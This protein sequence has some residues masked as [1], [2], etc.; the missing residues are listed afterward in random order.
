MPNTKIPHRSRERGA[1]ASGRFTLRRKLIWLLVPLLFV[2][3]APVIILS[4]WP[5]SSG[6]EP[7]ISYPEELR[8]Q[9]VQPADRFMQSVVTDDG[10]LGWHQLCPT[11][12]AQLPMDELVQQ[13][14][15]QRDVVVKQ[16]VR[17]TFKRVSVRSRQASGT[18]HEYVVT[19][20]WPNGSTQTRTFDVMTQP[21]GCVE[22][23]Q[24]H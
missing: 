21:S 13:A 9:P 15:A 14:N 16:G 17:L 4:Q 2:L 24:N 20:R 8:S 18:V 10:A 12:Q 6:P 22:D 1:Q 7:P 23:V 5:G 3:A 19:A 11:L